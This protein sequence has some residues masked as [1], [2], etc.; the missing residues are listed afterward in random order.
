MDD[1]WGYIDKTGKMV[2]EPQFDKVK[3]F[4][5]GLATVEINGKWGY[6]DKTG[7]MV[8][9]P[10]FDDTG[11]F[12]EGLAAAKKT[13][14]G[15]YEYID[16]TGKAVIEPQ[17]EK[18]GS[19]SEGLAPVEK[20]H[21]GLLRIGYEY[22]DK[23]GKAVIE[24]QLFNLAES[25]FEGLAAVEIDGKWG[26]IDKTGKIV[27]KPQFNEAWGF[28]EGL[29]LIHKHS[30]G[31]GI[32]YIDK[33]GKKV[34]ISQGGVLPF[35]D[36]LTPTRKPTLAVKWG[37]SDRT[38][39]VVIEPQFDKVGSFSEGLAPVAINY[40]WGYIDKTGKMV[41]EPQF[42]NAGCFSHG[43]AAVE[44]KKGCFIATAAYGS[45]MAK[46]VYKL[47]SWR[48]ESLSKIEFG[49]ILINIYYKISPPIAKTIEKSDIMKKI[50]RVLLKP[51][52]WF[53]KKSN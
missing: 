17:F 24:P 51:L 30:M 48:D 42:D 9:E 8:I 43:L 44:I 6:I 12:S 52:I 39:K 37:Y 25:F 36:G 7:R 41:I 27:I 29:A 21:T 14:S 50:V 2:I 4:S 10:Q 22:I 20:P 23:T 31:V 34:N 1:K 26:Y 19:F 3:A 5:G 16:K 47:R 15:L 49:R 38:N 35:S 46:E 33:T 45:S 11:S 32:G 28:S 13:Y 53:I 18:A 40:K